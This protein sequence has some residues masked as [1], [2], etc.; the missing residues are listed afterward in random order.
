MRYLFNENVPTHG[1]VFLEE[2]L[3]MGSTWVVQCINILS[4]GIYSESMLQIRSFISTI[5]FKPYFLLV[6][7][8][9]IESGFL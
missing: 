3:H 6:C 8:M 2:P 1:S 7:F 5:T 9:S 4:V